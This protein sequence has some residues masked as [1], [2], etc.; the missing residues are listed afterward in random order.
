[1]RCCAMSGHA[2]IARELFFAGAE[3]EKRD[4]DGK[5]ALM[6]KNFN[7]SSFDCLQVLPKNSVLHIL[8]YSINAVNLSMRLK[9]SHFEHK[10]R[11]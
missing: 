2:E 8:M 4:K 11:C 5:T 7:K 9:C 6:V 1:M 3:V 10:R